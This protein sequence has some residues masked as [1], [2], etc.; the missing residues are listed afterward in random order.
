MMTKLILVQWFFT[1]WTN[2]IPHEV[3]PFV[4]ETQCENMVQAYMDGGPFVGEKPDY[5]KPAYRPMC[6]RHEFVITS[7]NVKE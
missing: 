6:V 5:P 2:G 4:N 1:I 3:G 7:E